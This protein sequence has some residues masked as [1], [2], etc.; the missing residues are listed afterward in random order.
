[1]KFDPSAIQY[2]H[3]QCPPFDDAVADAHWPEAAYSDG[4]YLHCGGCDWT[5]GAEHGW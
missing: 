5:D 4:A 3:H 2:P 1:M